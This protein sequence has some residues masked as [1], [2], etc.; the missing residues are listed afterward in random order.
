M[1]FRLLYNREPKDPVN[2]DRQ[3]KASCV[4][5]VSLAYGT[6]SFSCSLAQLIQPQTGHYHMQSSPLSTRSGPLFP[7]PLALPLRLL[8][9]FVHSRTLVTTLNKLF[10]D[11]I[12]TGELDFLLDRLVHISIEDAGVDYRLT[13][14]GKNLLAG[15]QKQTPDLTLKGTLYNYMLLASRREDAD[16][17]FFSRR[18]HMQGDTE[19]GLYVKNFLDGLDMDSNT[20]PAMFESA[21]RKSLPWY[22]RLFG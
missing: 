20:V 5:I 16:T 8:P 4:I 12:R 14:N 9:P 22:E 7:A 11:S 10:E 2:Q 18:L 3:Q 21:I 1:L 19:L 13:F 17:M 6:Y 15:D